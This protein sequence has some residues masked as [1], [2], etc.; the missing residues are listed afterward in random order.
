MEISVNNVK[1][2]YEVSG[3]G[4]PLILLH[5]NG[6]SHKIFDR[7]VTDLDGRYTAYAIDSRC[8]GESQR[9]LPLSYGL[10]T[11]D[12]AGF[13]TKLKIDKPTVIGFSDGGI[14]CLLLAVKYPELVGKIIALGANATPDG[15]NPRLTRIMKILYKIIRSPKLKMMLTEPDITKEQLSAVSVPTVIV[16]GSND[17]ITA[18]HTKYIADNIPSAVLNILEGEGHASYVINSPKLYKVLRKFI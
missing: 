15:L 2:Y 10:M 5:G 13:I 14:I 18:E 9:K 1:L 4:A 7:F 16:A 12:V 8:H 17:M 11:D 6:E 3:E